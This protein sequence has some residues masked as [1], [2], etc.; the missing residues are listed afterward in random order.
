MGTSL[1]CILWCLPAFLI[2][3]R[4][5][6]SPRSA[7]SGR[8]QF[9]QGMTPVAISVITLSLASVLIGFLLAHPAP[10]MNPGLPLWFM[11][12]G[13]WVILAI[14]GIGLLPRVFPSSG[15]IRAIQLDAATRLMAGLAWASCWPTAWELAQSG[16]PTL[17]LLGA[18]FGVLPDTFDHWISRHLHRIH[19]HIVPDPLSPDTHMIAESLALALARCRDRHSRI[20]IQLYP[21]QTQTGQWH[22][23]TFCFDNL[24]RLL[25]ITH[26]QAS[27]VVPLPCAIT[28]DQSFTFETGNKPLCLEL[29]WIPDGR[30]TLRA[31]PNQQQWSHSL[32]TAMGF[33]VVAGVVW[34][35][36][37]G[38]IAGGA[39]ALHGIVD[40]L[41]FNGAG[42]QF[43]LPS[44][45]TLFQ[46]SVIWL[47]LLLTGW[48]GA[49]IIVP[50]STLPSL[51]SVLL[52]GGTLPYALLA[53][54]IKKKHL[55]AEGLVKRKTSRES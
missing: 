9:I 32:V 38:C 11:E 16:N 41:G 13:I 20:R 43:L 18:I 55:P 25:V 22:H 21:G 30:I 53:G 29:K 37:A 52:L 6:H 28:T 4:V 54:F 45:E 47:A 15:F 51:I 12:T 46:A 33:G 27:T 40:Q 34:G 23:Y 2:L 35:F 1:A 24:E 14:I 36:P 50:D 17:F 19:I 10:L 48:N 31:D 5:P 3:T 44:R 8:D 39:Y 26:D 7:L 42:L 49:R